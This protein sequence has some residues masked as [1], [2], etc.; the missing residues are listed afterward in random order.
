M[1]AQTSWTV[2][3][4]YPNMDMFDY[5]MNSQ[6]HLAKEKRVLTWNNDNQFFFLSLTVI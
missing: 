2:V 6:S 5:L 4:E 3:N 1:I